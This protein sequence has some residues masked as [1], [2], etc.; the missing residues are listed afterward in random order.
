MSHQNVPSIG[1]FKCHIKMFHLKVPNQF[2]LFFFS[3][4]LLFNFSTILLLKCSTFLHYSDYIGTFCGIL[5][6]LGTFWDVLGTFWD[7]LGCFWTFWEV[8]KHVGMFWDV[9]GCFF[10][11][12][13]VHFWVFGTFLDV[14][15]INIFKKIREFYNIL[16]K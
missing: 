12:V 5:G 8:L 11:N 7:V 14:I 10:F 6:R 9:L 3:T 16:E 15:L 13:F 1:P 4:F 2:L